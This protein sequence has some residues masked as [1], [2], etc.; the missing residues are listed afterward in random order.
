[1]CCVMRMVV[2]T[3]IKT[4]G[5]SVCAYSNV[6]FLLDSDVIKAHTQNMVR[7]S[8]FE[9]G[10]ARIRTHTFDVISQHVTLRA[11]RWQLC[12]FRTLREAFDR[13]HARAHFPNDAQLPQQVWEI[14]VR[15]GSETIDHSSVPITTCVYS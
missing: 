13:L 15:T 2:R 4:A 11:N 12:V 14:C 8:L 3:L 7:K 1:M 5:G 6:S 9:I 10:C